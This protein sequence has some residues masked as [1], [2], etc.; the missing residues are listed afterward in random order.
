M[1]FDEAVRAAVEALNPATERFRSAVTTTHEQVGAQLASHKA[2]AGARAEQTAREMGAFAAGHFDFERIAKLVE[3][4]D[5]LPA[6]GYERIG[7]AQK[8]LH[9]VLGS[10]ARTPVV[11]VPLGGNLHNAVAAALSLL[12]RAFG[13]ALSVQLAKS[14]RH[15]T[16]EHAGLLDGFAYSRWNK[17]ERQ[18]APPLVVSVDGSDLNAG[19]LAEFLDGTQKLLLVVREAC[20]PAALVRL[21]TPGTFVMQTSTPADLARFAAFAG[22]GVAALV[23]EGSARFVHDPAGGAEMGARLA[24]TFMP[25][26]LPTHP[27][28]AISVGQQV[29]ELKQL[30]A[31]GVMSASAAAGTVATWAKDFGASSGNGAAKSSD[32]VD[33]LA[34]WLLRQAKFDVKA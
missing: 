27:V 33:L 10:V 34:G 7:Q 17:S 30:A 13:A 18:V 12:G 22:P 8:A 1:P 16:A 21:I 26:K 4:T 6:A 20:P 28:G 11:T 29:E 25:A 15:G 5:V 9:D 32:P 23:P 19:G 2:G 14:G 24:V 3:H 31:L